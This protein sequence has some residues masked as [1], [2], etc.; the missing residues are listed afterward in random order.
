MSFQNPIRK[1]VLVKHKEELLLVGLQC[2]IVVKISSMWVPCL[3]P[4][5]DRTTSDCPLRDH[6]I[7]QGAATTAIL[8]SST[9]HRVITFTWAD[10]GFQHSAHSYCTTAFT[11]SIVHK[12]KTRPSAIPAR[13]RMSCSY[14]RSSGFML[15]SFA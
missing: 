5:R 6:A 9:C 2:V 13:N 11:S 10:Y 1:Q 8:F 7:H 12:C 3:M 4:E 15:T 14:A